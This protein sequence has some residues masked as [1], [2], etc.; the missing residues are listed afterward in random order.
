ML[1][2]PF[3][4][5][6]HVHSLTP[7]LYTVRS[8]QTVG[9][10][11]DLLPVYQAGTNVEPWVFSPSYYVTSLHSVSIPA[12]PSTLFLPLAIVESP[13][14]TEPLGCTHPHAHEHTH[15]YPGTCLWLWFQRR[16]SFGP[17]NWILRLYHPQMNG[18]KS[19]TYT[20]MHVY[21]RTHRDTH[22]QEWE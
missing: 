4:S 15:I 12:W 17:M 9:C 6:L 11:F 16:L 21:T 8:F 3:S 20:G 7:W 5:I 22:T 19:R 2:F 14:E 10:L 13:K 1:V 18:T